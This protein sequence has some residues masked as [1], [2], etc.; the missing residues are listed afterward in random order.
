MM[1]EKS[2][3]QTGEDPKGTQVSDDTAGVDVR[4]RREATEQDGAMAA[5]RTDGSQALADGQA[6]GPA[7]AGGEVPGSGSSQPGTEP[8]MDPSVPED[9][10]TESSQIKASRTGAPIDLASLPDMR[11]DHAQEQ[12]SRAGLD[13]S[14][15]DK[16][17]E[18]FT[19]VYDIIDRVQSTLD[20][21]KSLILSPGMVKLDREELTDELNDL[22]KMLPV[23]LERASALMREAQ[24]RLDA[25]QTQANA[26]VTAAQS[27]AA[28]IVKEAGDQ[29]Q[30][31]AGQENVVAIAQDKAR[32]IIDQ[33]QAQAD[34]LVQGADGYAAQVMQALDG[35]LD[36]FKQDVNAGLGVLKTREQEAARAMNAGHEET[37]R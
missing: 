4:F 36:K 32:T 33:A 16:S 8:V 27:R 5:D 31:L 30:F 28:D 34:K 17:R 37:G 14:G 18:E 9:D 15:G 25:A 11:E 21:S 12:P 10:S 2:D 7:Q 23:Q 35:Q 13:E 1:V 19:T 26:T 29:A 24:R 20:G 6:E 3:G 22:K